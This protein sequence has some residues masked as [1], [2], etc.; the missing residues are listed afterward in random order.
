MKKRNHIVL[1]TVNYPHVIRELFDNINKYNHIDEVKVWII[2]DCKTPPGLFELSGEFNRKGLEIAYLDIDVQDRWGKRCTEFYN[3][4]P[5]NNEARRNIGYL[6]ALEDGCEVLISID[7]DNF[8]TDDDF[9]GV[10]SQTG[11]CFDGAILKDDEGF[12]NICEHLSFEPSRQV[13]P[14]G[15]PFELRGKSNNARY[16]KSDGIVR[17]GVTMGLWLKE[18]DI[19]A[20]TWLNGE[21]LSKSYNSQERIVLEQS[22]WTPVN[23]QNTSVIR[24]LVPAFLCVPMGWDV[25][26]G[27]IQR[28]GDIWGGYFL[29]ALMEGTP[30]H[31]SFGRPLVEHRRNPHNY[32][33]DL[34][35]EFWAMTLTDWLLTVLRECFKPSS[36][37]MTERVKELAAFIKDE[38][39]GEIP[40]WC[41]KELKDF[42]E[43]TSGNLR[44]WALA[45]ET[46]AIDEPVPS[47]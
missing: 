1:T 15:F 40:H 27:K 21:I 44:A 24:E 43:W 34:R 8:P 42:L 7:D 41:P 32:I 35:S 38:A 28:Y 5:Y 2:G 16:I 14:R 29:Q 12:H 20:T 31:V 39:I 23:T 30:Y 10:H 11:A 33:D 3:R 6:C 47:V 4:I 25:P 37:L 22:T 45:C 17:V 19:D 13:F 36:S 18:P 26:G 46:I 9:V